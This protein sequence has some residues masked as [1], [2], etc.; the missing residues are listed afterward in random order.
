MP[1]RVLTIAI[2]T[3]AL[4]PALARAQ[5]PLAAGWAPLIRANLGYAYVSVSD[6]QNRLAS[7]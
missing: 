4:L 7:V 5:G 1:R 2:L 6:T 3:L